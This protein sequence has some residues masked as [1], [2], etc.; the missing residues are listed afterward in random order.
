MDFLINEYVEKNKYKGIKDNSNQNN[1][2]ATVGELYVIDYLYSKGFSIEFTKRGLKDTI[3]II[4]DNTSMPFEFRAC[5]KKK[6]YKEIC[7][8]IIIEYNRFCE[9]QYL[10]EQVKKG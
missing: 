5:L 2:F 4:K 8:R 3:V 6:E 9:L 7:E 10:R 1:K